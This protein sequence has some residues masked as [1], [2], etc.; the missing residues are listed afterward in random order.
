L[1]PLQRAWRRG[2]RRLR[3]GH[4]LRLGPVAVVRARL[5]DNLLLRLGDAEKR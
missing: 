5:L 4:V 3:E 2:H 1:G